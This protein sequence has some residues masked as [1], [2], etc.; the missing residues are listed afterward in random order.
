MVAVKAWLLVLGLAVLLPVCASQRPAAKA[1]C[2][3][4]SGGVCGR[5]CQLHICNALGRFYRATL[6]ETDPWDNE[7]GWELTATTTC[8][9]LVGRGAQRQAVYCRW[10][11]I[12]CCSPE[13]MAAGNCSAINSVYSIQMPINNL[14]G[15]VGNIEMVQPMQ[16]VH[17][18]GMRILN[19]EANNLVGQFHPAWGALKDL[20]VFNYGNCWI[21]GS[22]PNSMRSMRNLTQINLSNN[23]LN[24]TL[25][26]WLDEFQQLRILNLGSQFG[27][28]EG[29]ESVGLTGTVPR[30]L[31]ELRELRELNLESNALT[32]ELPAMLCHGDDSNLLVLNLR[33]NQLSGNA[34]IVESC[35]NLVTLDVSH[36]DFEGP[37]P[38]SE[39]WD[40]LASYRT[41]HNRLS[42]TFPAKLATSARI[43][44]HLDV[45]SNLLTGRLPN[46]VTILSGL[47]T[48]LMSGNRFTGTL[49]E[50]VFFLPALMVF[51]VSNNSFVGTIHEAIG[52]SYSLQSIDYSNN[53][54]ITG[55]IPPQMGLLQ[56]L[57]TARLQNTSLSCSGIIKPYTVTTNA[58]CSDPGRCKTPK[59][60]GDEVIGQHVCSEQEQLPCFLKFSD[61]LLPREDASNMRCKY[62]VRLPRDKALEACA[63]SPDADPTDLGDYA[64]LLAD[65]RPEA[66][67]Q[68]WYVDPSYFQYQ[69][70]ECLMGY[71]AE[72]DAHRT[73]LT[74]T[75]Q[76]P[77][78]AADQR[79]AIIVSSIAGA[80]VLAL[81][82]LV[83]RQY[84]TTRPRWLRERVMQAKR[85]KGPPRC[86]KAGDKVTVSV[87]VTDVKDFS[88]LTRKCPELM[89]KAMGGHNNI[90]RKACHTHAGYVMDQEG[91][92]WSV[93]FHSAEDAVGFSLQV[94]QAL[95]QKVWGMRL[96]ASE[97]ALAE[98]RNMTTMRDEGFSSKLTSGMLAGSNSTAAAA[99]AT[100][101]HLRSNSRTPLQARHSQESGYVTPTASAQQQQ[102]QQQQQ[103][104]NGAAATLDINNSWTSAQHPALAG[105]AHG[106]SSFGSSVHWTGPDRASGSMTHKAS[107]SSSKVWMHNAAAFVRRFSQFGR[108]GSSQQQ[109]LRAASEHVP[110]QV[111]RLALRVGIATGTLPYGVDVASCAVKDRAK[112]MVCDVANAGQILM[113]EPTFLLVKDS[114]SALG[115]VNEGGYDDAML[116]QLMQSQAIG[117]LQQQVAC[118]GVCARRQHSSQSFSSDA[119]AQDHQDYD[120]DAIVVHMGCFEVPAPNADDSSGGHG[121][122]NS[123]LAAMQPSADSQIELVVPRAAAAAAARS[124]AKQGGK[125]A[126][127]QAKQQLHLYSVAAPGM[128]QRASSTEQLSR[129][130]S[131]SDAVNMRPGWVQV[132]KGFWEAPGAREMDLSPSTGV[133]QASHAPLPDVTIVFAVVA[134]AAGFTFKRSRSDT[135]YVNKVIRRCMLQQL[136]VLPGGDGYLCRCQEADLKYMVAFENPHKAV[137][138][139]LAVQE[140]LLYAHWPASV[141]S[142]PGFEQV[143]DPASGLPL[144]RGPRLRMGLAE[145]QPNSV[146]PD[147]NGRANYWGSCVN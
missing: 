19:L 72:W 115:T 41:S 71:R 92:S 106:K 70:C 96:G 104:C 34:T 63:G 144:F 147:H 59:R 146:V 133:Y 80:L 39:Q 84:L 7:Y 65:V 123:L 139:C 121:T 2:P 13:G 98:L 91:D 28:N 33:G 114:L 18:C 109:Q 110:M 23:W 68:S 3:G 74:C 132:Q 140:A 6:N 111:L 134:G 57:Q 53:P 136:A 40:E 48:L 10:F 119:L 51:D 90:L 135:R 58:S 128:R 113:D 60:F 26:D 66:Y 54:G 38:A 24:G 83:W 116:Q 131:W 89:N 100:A 129:I 117:K 85:T 12:T 29:S 93:A 101:P 36:N 143:L 47:K 8:E 1:L 69:Q 49:T 99:A 56:G 102:Q 37:M 50:D 138:W 9:Q 46:Q 64:P 16:Q 31:S 45:S 145:G 130:L 127:P 21:S 142:H 77:S 108:S 5:A 78:S 22:I 95:A 125:H 76:P 105:A 103:H 73:T 25:P 137:Q 35:G 81:L 88:E 112:D 52:L 44:E 27:D 118:G 4:V 75:P 126:Q 61:Y 20:L 141:L 62:I 94:Q 17:D 30:Q 43:L 11:G 124:S 87:V 14:N 42:G 79:T 15:S 67:E 86:T 107:D 122:T 55:R 32:G 120:N 82:L 97:A